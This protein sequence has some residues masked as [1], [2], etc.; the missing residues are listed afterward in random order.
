MQMK[1]NRRGLIAIGLLTISG[2]LCLGMGAQ[3]KRQGRLLAVHL[4]SG[5]HS[6]AASAVAMTTLSPAPPVS[7]RQV[8]NFN[9]SGPGSL[10]QTI[11][12]ANAGDAILLGAAG[13]YSLTSGEITID[14]DLRIFGFGVGSTVI[15]GSNNSRIFSINVNV[16]IQ[17]IDLVLVNG[18]STQNGG[19]IYQ[20]GGQLT[21]DKCELSKQLCCR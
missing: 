8:Q 6:K 2:I 9:D 4:L 5:A 3:L 15:S 7:V 18:K 19:A 13:T 14:K 11:T 21:L 10:R 12:E 20:S 1:M 16:T 17:L